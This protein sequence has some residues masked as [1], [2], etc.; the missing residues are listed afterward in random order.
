MRELSP[1][2]RYSLAG[3][4]SFATLCFVGGL[5]AVE[6]VSVL[7]YL[8]GAA[9]VGAVWM[10]MP[11]SSQHVGLARERGY[12]ALPVTLL[13]PVTAPLVLVFLLIALSDRPR[14]MLGG[15]LLAC[16]AITGLV[17]L[18]PPRAS[19]NASQGG[20]ATPSVR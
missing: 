16:V 4:L 9:F 11:V 3:M 7:T 10:T 19:G 20:L 14:V 6:G 8:L 15:A 13:W 12:V 17:V 2:S 1:K 18:D 5:V